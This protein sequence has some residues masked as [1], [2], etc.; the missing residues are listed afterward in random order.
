MNRV[1]GVAFEIGL[2]LRHPLIAALACGLALPPLLVLGFALGS[3][4]ESRAVCQS[5]CSAYSAGAVGNS[6]LESHQ[7][8]TICSETPDT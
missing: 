4:H 7:F 5:P 6:M 1:T 2:Q 3:D 8:D